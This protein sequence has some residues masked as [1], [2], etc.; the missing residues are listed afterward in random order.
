MLQNTTAKHGQ[1]VFM[2]IIHSFERDMCSYGIV[3][4]FQMKGTAIL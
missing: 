4:H 1:S 2:S 3:L